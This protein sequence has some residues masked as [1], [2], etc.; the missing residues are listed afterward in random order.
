[1]HIRNCVEN[2]TGWEKYKKPHKQKHTQNYKWCTVIVLWIR[3]VV[4]AVDRAH[5]VIGSSLQFIL[6]VV[7]SV[8]CTAHS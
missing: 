5:T 2:Y 6:M 3:N 8:H 7:M 4:S 1:M